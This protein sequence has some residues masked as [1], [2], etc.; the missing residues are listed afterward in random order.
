MID[1]QATELITPEQRQQI[2]KLIELTQS[3]L[4]KAL[5]YYGVESLD[6]LSKTAA[7]NFIKKLNT[8]LDEASQQIGDE[9]PL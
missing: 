5:A 8:K 9:I 3:N 6:K 2:D 1:V 4:E 7:E